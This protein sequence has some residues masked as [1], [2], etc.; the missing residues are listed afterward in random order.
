MQIVVNSILT[1]YQDIGGK[2]N[3]ILL[4]LPGWMRQA[5]EW[6]PVAQKFSHKYRVVIL[7]FPGF[8]NSPPPP[9][10]W[11]VPEYADFTKS[12]L[13]KLNISKCIILGHSFGGR[14]GIILSTETNLLEKL[15]LVDAA[16]LKEYKF[17]YRLKRSTAFYLA[18]PLKKFFPPLARMAAS[19]FG[20]DDYKKAGDMRKILIKVVNHDSKNALPKIQIPTIIIWG[21]NDNVLPVSQAKKMK[22]QVPNSILRVVWGSGHSPHLEK[23]KQ[24]T[25]IL[26]EYLYTKY[27]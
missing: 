24:F 12:F 17:S 19:F 8:G 6:L 7:D 27:V 26:N 15:I 21:E 13:K 5:V 20:S 9:P 4:I 2:N 3:P 18:K 23:E 1:S 16:G 25:Q 10:S 11:G 22:S 14:V